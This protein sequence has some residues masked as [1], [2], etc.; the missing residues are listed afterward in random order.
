M[1]TKYDL[2]RD[3]NGA[4]WDS[5]PFAQDGFV[6]QLSQN[7]EQHI[8]VPSNYPSW[9]AVFTYSVGS[10]VWVNG[11]TTATV[12]SGSFA[13]GTSECNPDRRHVKAGQTISFITPDSAGALV[14]VKF[15]YT[16]FYTN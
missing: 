16:S 9:E 1:S 15:L 6:G 10:N 7:T 11:I 8:T 5:I 2:T 3:V 4:W 12:P 14:S 13:A